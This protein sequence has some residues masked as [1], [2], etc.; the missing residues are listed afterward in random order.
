MQSV[1]KFL[2]FVLLEIIVFMRRDMSWLFVA[3]FEAEMIL[4]LVSS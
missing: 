4:D 1:G 2:T 3:L